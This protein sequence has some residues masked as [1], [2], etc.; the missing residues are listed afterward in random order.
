MLL[1]PELFGL[2]GLS[3]ESGVVDVS[4]DECRNSTDETKRNRG[5]CIFHEFCCCNDSECVKCGIVVVSDTL[6][7]DDGITSVEEPF[8]VLF[9]LIVI[10]SELWP[11]LIISLFVVVEL[12]DS[13]S[14][15][16]GCS[17]ECVNWEQSAA[18]G[19]ES[20]WYVDDKWDDACCPPVNN[21]I[22]EGLCWCF[23]GSV[24][25]GNCDTSRRFGSGSFSVANDREKKMVLSKVLHF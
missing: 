18:T 16:G 24:G 5:G 14:F 20:I 11:S 15:R 13:D 3:G 2:F 10:A 8:P 19:R 22:N 25:A 7:I 9:W 6:P 12:L 23:G 1:S 21:D 17:V 4:P